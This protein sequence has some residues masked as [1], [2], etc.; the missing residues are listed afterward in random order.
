N[1]KKSLLNPKHCIYQFAS[2][3]TQGA[4]D[5]ELS[6]ND[7]QIAA[8]DLDFSFNLDD[9]SQSAR[10]YVS[11]AQLNT[12][13]EAQATAAGVL[14]AVLGESTRTA[15]RHLFSF[16]GGSF[17]DLFKDIRRTLKRQDR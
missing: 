5:Q 1:F 15:F 13:R 14:N 10:Q 8:E 4:T 2:R 17:L 9:L 7:Y 16:N 11:R 12:N 6:R 3:L